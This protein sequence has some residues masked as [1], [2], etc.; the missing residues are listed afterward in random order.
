[1]QVRQKLVYMALGGVLVLAG[2]VLPSLVVP[3]ATAQ[4]GPQDAEFNEVTVRKLSVVDEATGATTVTLESF[5]GQAAGSISVYQPNGTEGAVLWAAEDG[6]RIDVYHGNG[7]SIAGLEATSMG[8]LV[9]VKDKDGEPEAGIA[10]D[11][12]GDGEVYR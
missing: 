3:S 11:E 4:H 12:N 2:H 10:V 1:M 6:G 7:K 9:W 8:G 5:L